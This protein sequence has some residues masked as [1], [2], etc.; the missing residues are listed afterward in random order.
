MLRDVGISWRRDPCLWFGISG[1]AWP[2]RRFP[3]TNFSLPLLLAA[4][5]LQRCFLRM[6]H[7]G[8]SRNGQGEKDDRWQKRCCNRLVLAMVSTL[9]A[10]TLHAPIISSSTE[11]WPSKACEARKLEPYTPHRRDTIRITCQASAGA[12]RSTG[13]SVHNFPLSRT[14]NNH[15]ALDQALTAPIM[16]RA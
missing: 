13:G 1:L 9:F 14:I 10:A 3:E 16:D 15:S 5:Q 8:F 6:L 11:Y 7:V 4:V 2:I 12:K